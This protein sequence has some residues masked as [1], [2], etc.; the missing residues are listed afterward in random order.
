MINKE[1][2]WFIVGVALLL[3]EIAAPGVVLLFLAAGAWLVAGLVAVGLLD[4][5]NTELIV[6]GVSS[7]VL[8][9]AL[10]KYVKGWFKG[11]EKSGSESLDNEFLEMK[12]LVT[13]EIVGGGAAGRVELKGAEWGASSSSSFKVG[14]TVTIVRRDGIDLE[15]E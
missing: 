15:V 10:R 6:F 14:D 1:L 12:V 9:L 4:N 2:I 5:W 13:K 8:M 3:G 7:V 11:G